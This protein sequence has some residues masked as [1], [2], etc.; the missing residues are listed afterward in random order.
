MVPSVVRRTAIVSASTALLFTGASV[1][2]GPAGAKPMGPAA[3]AK[4]KIVSSALAGVAVAP[5]STV[6]FAFGTHATLTT[7][8]IF[9]TKRK[10]G[11]WKSLP[12][13]KPNGSTTYSG[14]AA[15]APNSAWIVGTTYDQ[16]TN[17]PLIQHS[18]G[19]GFKPMKNHLGSGSL[20]DVA[21]ASKSSAWVVGAT[22]SSTAL[23]ARWNGHKWSKVKAPSTPGLVL[24]HVSMSSAKNVWILG[25]G[26]SGPVVGHWNGHRLTF[27][28]LK[29]PAEVNPSDIATASAKS[30]WVVGTK[31][32][33]TTGKLVPFTTHWNGHSWKAVSAPS[34]GFRSQPNS[35][36]MAGS[37]AFLAGQDVSKKGTT[38]TP[39]ALRFA[40][41]KWHTVKTV[42]RGKQSEFRSVAVSSKL[43]VAVGDWSLRGQC[44]TNPTPVNP[45][46][47]ELRGSSFGTSPTP[48]LRPAARATRAG[49]YTPDVPSC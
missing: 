35:V 25:S 38:F 37:K 20:S 46:L 30:T 3:P 14:I 24:S 16:T 19:S 42:K 32:V 40:G 29:V 43:V 17:S 18:T 9:A 26:S 5:H 10:G 39:F 2:I 11:H 31:A 15:G 34:P 36:S 8:S 21:A 41:G 47:E 23:A 22:S 28:S 1:A 27:K 7:N 33:G 4:S 49:W 13:K 45:L 6:G 44:V 12:I 48:H